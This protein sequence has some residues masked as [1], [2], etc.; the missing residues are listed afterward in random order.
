MESY[1]TISDT[2]CNSYTSPSGNDVWTTSGTYQDLLVNSFG[3]DSIIT[4][5]LTVNY[6]NAGTDVLTAC[7]SLTWIDGITYT[8]SNDTAF[9]V[10]TNAAGC[11]SLVTLDLTINTV[12][13]GIEADKANLS[14]MAEGASYQWLDCGNEYAKLEGEIEQF[15]IAQI[16]GEYAVSVSENGCTDTSSCVSVSSVGIFEQGLFITVSIYPN[17]NNGVV[18]IDFGT[19]GTYGL[20]VY[21]S[22]GR[23]IHQKEDIPGGIHQFSLEE[24]P[25]IYLIELSSGDR[26][27]NYRL[28]KK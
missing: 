1:A 9:Y 25:G 13:V 26:K 24:A 7:D 10:L 27:R 6:S 14:A 5:E 19:T 22:T 11:D 21:S 28:V 2:V 3:C 20:K 18:N 17:P 15:C 4:I 23:L 12:N 8:K 16:N